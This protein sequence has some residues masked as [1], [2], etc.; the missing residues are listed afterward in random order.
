MKSN[1]FL[2]V[3]VI[4][5]LVQGYLGQETC[6]EKCSEECTCPE[7]KVCTDTEIDCGPSSE[8]PVGH[9]DPDRICVASNCQCTFNEI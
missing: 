1:F 9:C 8:T 3:F 5:F 4:V 6:D 7:R 2:L